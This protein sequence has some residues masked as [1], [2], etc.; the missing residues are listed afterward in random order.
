MEKFSI[1]TGIACPL[2]FANIDT[3][4]IIPKQFLLSVSKKGF[5]KHLFHDLR[6]LDDEENVPNLDFNLNKTEYKNASILLT[7]DNFGNGSSREHAPWA[8]MDYGIRAVIAPSF[9]DIF[10]NNALGNGLL[11]I[12]LANDE[13]QWL[14][15]ELERSENKQMTISLIDK[16]LSFSGKELYF[17]LDDFHRNC[18]LEGLDNIGL[19]LKHQEYIKA[20]EEKAKSFLV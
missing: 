8:L 15:D 3:D 9:A 4:Q 10:K 19:T 6:Y 12:V 14:M 11:T 5:G 1:H 20:Y 17:D 18:L 16:K 7:R 13:V 2:D